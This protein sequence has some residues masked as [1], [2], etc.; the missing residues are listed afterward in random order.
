MQIFQKD[1][2]EY[3]MLAL[4]IAIGSFFYFHVF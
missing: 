4:Y 1:K 3:Y 2:Y